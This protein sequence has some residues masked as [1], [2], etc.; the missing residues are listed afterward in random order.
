MNFGEAM[1]EMA[2]KLRAADIGLNVYDFPARNPVPPCAVFLLPE[3]FTYDATYRRGMD[4]FVVPMI[5]V[6]GLVHDRDTRDRMAAYLDGGG[7]TSIKTIL[8]T[9]P[10]TAFDTIHVTGGSVS[11]ALIRAKKRWMRDCRYE[12]Q[13]QSSVKGAALLGKRYLFAGG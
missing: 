5:L 4:R 2:V 1:T 8:E 6:V 13:E 7:S 11:P 10:H 12:V 9:K 3:N